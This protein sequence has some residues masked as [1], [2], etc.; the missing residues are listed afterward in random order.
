MQNDYAQWLS[1]TPE[2][3]TETNEYGQKELNNWGVVERRDGWL[4]KIYA[5]TI[6]QMKKHRREVTSKH[7]K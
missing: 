1:A 4:L 2:K 5:A 7:E 3:R 6:S